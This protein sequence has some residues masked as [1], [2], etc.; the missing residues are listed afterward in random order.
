MEVKDVQIGNC[1]KRCDIYGICLFKVKSFENIE[2]KLPYEKGMHITTEK[3]III[4]T[5]AI[6]SEYSFVFLSPTDTVEEINES[7][8]D[9]AIKQFNMDKAVIS[10]IINQNKQ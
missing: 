9:K 4:R 6:S 5:Y 3:A 10:A 1:Y 2:G 7:I 8:L